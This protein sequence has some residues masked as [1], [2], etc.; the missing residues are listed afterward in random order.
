MNIYRVTAETEHNA[1]FGNRPAEIEFDVAA[2]DMTKAVAAA[3]VFIKDKKYKGK[4]IPAVQIRDIR[5]VS[6]V[7]DFYEV[8]SAAFREEAED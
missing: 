4:N 3:E 7:D 8:D 5:R 2:D 6:K 1:R